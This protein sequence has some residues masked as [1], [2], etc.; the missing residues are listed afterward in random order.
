MQPQCMNEVN[1]SEIHYV[2]EQY[3]SCGSFIYIAKYHK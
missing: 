2:Y 1:F 3:Y